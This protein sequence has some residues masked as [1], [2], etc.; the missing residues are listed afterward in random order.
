MEVFT[1]VNKTSFEITTEEQLD[2]LSDPFT[3]A[4]LG[5]LEVDEGKTVEDI[6]IELE[7]DKDH[8]KEYLLM[9]EK[10]DMVDWEEDGDQRFYF[11][12]A[13]Y[14]DLSDEFVSELPE[15]IQHHWIFGILSSLQGEYYD[16]FR[17]IKNVGYDNL[18]DALEDK[19]Y[20]NSVD[21]FRLSVNRLD[22]EKGDLQKMYN[23]IMDIVHKY[24]EKG[25]EAE[26]SLS[27]DLSLFVKPRIG[28]FMK[29]PK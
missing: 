2:L 12:K 18:D 24:D 21:S 7:D 1:M 4:V 28:E 13:D 16:L 5:I 9:L 25:V 6:F 14:Y 11:K 19:G 26:N 29:K 20:P 23:E 3:L 22:L 10:S 27:F 15:N 8:I 17:N